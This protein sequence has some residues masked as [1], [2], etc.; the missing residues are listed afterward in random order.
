MQHTTNTIYH[1]SLSFL[2]L[3]TPRHKLL[4]AYKMLDFASYISILFKR[5]IYIYI[6]VTFELFISY[7]NW[8]KLSIP[9][10]MT[11]F[12]ISEVYE[13]ISGK[14]LNR[15]ILLERASK[16]SFYNKYFKIYKMIFRI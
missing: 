2:T 16:I 9:K 8:N 15:I 5:I 4:L 12:S 10:S 6:I 1:Y 11:Y 7:K 13:V 14:N 3:I